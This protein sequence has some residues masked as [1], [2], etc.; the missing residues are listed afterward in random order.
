MNDT[1]LLAQI[2]YW[3]ESDSRQTLIFFSVVGGLI[4]LGILYGW[5]KNAA[6]GGGSKKEGRSTRTF[7]RGSFRRKAY[8]AGFSDTESDFLEQY[9]RKIGT[10]NPAAIFSN[11]AQ[12]DSFMRSAFKYIERHAD[13][14]ESAE[15]NKTK[16]FSLREALG[17]RL[18]SGTP[19]RSTRKLQARTPL[20]IVTAKNANYASILIANESK[21]LYVEPALD[22]F[23]QAIKFHWFSRVTVYF[24]TGNHI[25]YSFK[26]RAGGMINMDGRPL[27]ALYHSDKVNPLPSRRN[28][29]RESRL[30]CHFYLLHIRAVKDRGKIV[31]SIQVEKAAVAGILTDL[32]AGGV[33]MQTMSPVKSG[34]FIKLEFDV[35]NGNR[36]AYASVVR[37]NRLRNG[38]SMHLKFVKISRKTVNEIL[39]Y[40]YGYD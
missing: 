8:E 23:G 37:T 21:A 18:S 1:I 7:S 14:E 6:E 28:Q 29:R 4:V 13:T 19:I 10:T 20:S 5:L 9:A 33:S 32:S 2:T 31:K 25:G 22:A 3:K 35:G 24:Y 17:M 39:A 15:E 12:L 36:M 34:E 16:L 38:A 27:L 40:V 26:T 30:S 11:R